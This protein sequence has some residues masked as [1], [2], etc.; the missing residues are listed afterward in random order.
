MFYY[1]NTIAIVNIV[2]PVL[3]GLAVLARLSA[4]RLTKLTFQADDWLILVAWVRLLF[5]QS[6]RHQILTASIG[7]DLF[8][9]DSYRRRSVQLGLWGS[10]DQG[11][12]GNCF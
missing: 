10:I 12:F 2:F 9:R 8:R 6:L 4:R 5:T 11:P 1:Q 7:C 3:A